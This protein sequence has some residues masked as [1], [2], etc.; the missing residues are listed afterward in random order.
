[1][2]NLIQVDLSKRYGNLRNG[3]NDIKKHTWFNQTEWMALYQRQIV[4]PIIP[5]RKRDPGE[6]ARDQEC[7]E[8]D[9]FVR[10]EAQPLFAKDFE[11]F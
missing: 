6:T 9:P 10:L 4:A 1:M 7:E 2:R 8:N 5:N 3:V 11:D